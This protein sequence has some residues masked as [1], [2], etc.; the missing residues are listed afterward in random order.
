MLQRLNEDFLDALDKEDVIAKETDVESTDGIKDPS[1]FKFWITLGTH[2][3]CPK[4]TY[5][6]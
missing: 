4:N 2:Q 6:S 3:S 1:E 5:K